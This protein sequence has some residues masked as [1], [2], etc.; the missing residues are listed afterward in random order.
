MLQPPATFQQLRAL[1]WSAA[2]L[3]GTL[4]GSVSWS[5]GLLTGSGSLT[6]GLVAGVLSWLAAWSA[7]WLSNFGVRHNRVVA[8]WLFLGIGLPLGWLLAPAIAPMDRHGWGLV[9]V[10]GLAQLLVLAAGIAMHRREAVITP[11][12]RSLDW[13]GHVRIDLRAFSIAKLD[14]PGSGGTPKVWLPA[15]IIG[16]LSVVTFQVLQHWLMP[17]SLALL[18]FVVANAMAA[19]LTLGPIARSL[20]QSARLASLE[21]GSP[22]RFA[23]AR[24]AWLARE[25]HQTSFGRWL[26]NRTKAPR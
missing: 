12:A 2:L 25:R 26:H 6:L 10:T 4:W 19:W 20:A 22:R 15:S 18:G 7:V 14:A 13:P 8:T 17:D 5:L 23:T 21:S 3:V 9:S 16:A 24:L 11:E 1:P